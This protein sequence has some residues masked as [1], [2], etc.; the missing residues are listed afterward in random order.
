[1]SEQSPVTFHAP[2]AGSRTAGEIIRDARQAQGLTLEQLAGAIKVSVAKLSALEE[3][4]FDELPDANFAR[5]LAM[6]LCRSLKLDTA[7]V[8]ARLPAAKTAS[9]VTDKQPLNQPFKDVRRSSPLFEHGFNWSSLLSFKWL[10]PATLLLAAGAV[11]L[12]P[13]S[14]EM[15]A[16]LQWPAASAPAAASAPEPSASSEA[17]LPQPPA[18]EPASA[19]SGAVITYVPV[20]PASTPSSATLSL[21]VSEAAA[22]SPSGAASAS[23]AASTVAPVVGHDLVLNVS[24]SSWVDV[25]DVKGIKLLSRQVEAGEVLTLQGRAPLKLNIGNAP[26]VRV[27]YSGLPVDLAPYTRANVARLELK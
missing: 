11:Y 10:A 1:M 15:P 22:Q 6:T 12:V 7:E 26:S 25:R 5:A 4:R 24:S 23:A 2:D 18:S 19:A 9:L 17:L 27:T 21:D 14:I 8:L 13:D 20:A 3:G 16:W